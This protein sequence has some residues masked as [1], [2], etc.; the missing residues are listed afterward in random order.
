MAPMRARAGSSSSSRTVLSASFAAEFSS[1]C[2]AASAAEAAFFGCEH[3]L[4]PAKRHVL[5]RVVH[6]AVIVVAVDRVAR[7]ADVNRAERR[8]QELVRDATGKID[9]LLKT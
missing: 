3:H 7:H 8:K 9:K 6:R 2:P 4:R 1:T 5:E